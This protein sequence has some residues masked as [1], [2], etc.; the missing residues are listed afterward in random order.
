MTSYRVVCCEQT[1]CTQSGHIVG[2]G[3]GSDPDSATVQWTVAEVWNAIDSGDAFYTEAY[4]YR[5][6][7]EKFRCPCGR[8]SLRSAA[9]AIT[10]N[11][12]DNL[13]ICRWRAA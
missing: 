12:L 2:V 11:N 13:R 10:A 8:G 5:A 7:V 6:R 3:T 9:D 4:G 1:G